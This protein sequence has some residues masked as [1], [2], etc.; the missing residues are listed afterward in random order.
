MYEGFQITIIG[1][2]KKP[3]FHKSIHD[4]RSGIIK[5]RWMMPSEGCLHYTDNR[6]V[7]KNGFSGN[8][9]CKTAYLRLVQDCE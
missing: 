2:S 8:V 9:Q 6:F 5:I 7:C 4:E 3:L 1:S